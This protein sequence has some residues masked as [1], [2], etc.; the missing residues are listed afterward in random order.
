MASG[1]KFYK[2]SME[3]INNLERKLKLKKIITLLLSATGLV[4]YTYSLYCGITG[5]VDLMQSMSSRPTSMYLWEGLA[6]FSILIF[7]IPL[8]LSKIKNLIKIGEV[9][10]IIMLIIIIILG[11]LKRFL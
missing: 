3:V 7:G 4:A 8:K 11:L 2:C 9:S 5:K 6:L 10:S 1:I